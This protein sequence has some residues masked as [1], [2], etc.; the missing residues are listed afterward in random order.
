MFEKL[1]KKL[2]KRIGLQVL[3]KDTLQKGFITNFVILQEENGQLPYTVKYMVH[4]S[5]SFI[6][7]VDERNL[8]IFK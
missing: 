7:C 4:F 8:V 1:E 3:T 2:K 5:D 6:K